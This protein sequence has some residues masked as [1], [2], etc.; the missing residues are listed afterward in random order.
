MAF[1]SGRWALTTGMEP[2]S[3]TPNTGK[4]FHQNPPTRTSFRRSWRTTEPI[5][6]KTCNV[7]V[8]CLSLAASAHSE[9]RW[10]SQ[11]L[12][13]KWLDFGKSCSCGQNSWTCCV[14][15]K[16]RNNS[17]GGVWGEL[18]C[19]V[20]K[21][22]YCW[23]G[24]REDATKHSDCCRNQ[25]L[26]ILNPFESWWKEETRPDEGTNLHKTPEVFPLGNFWSDIMMSYVY[27]N[28]NV[29]FYKKN[30]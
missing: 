2:S 18:S 30:F 25:R 5:W 28:R 8:C 7:S 27:Y 4:W 3:K 15:R 14:C 13:S 29:L 6:V 20:P 17:G 19:S 24:T 26:P 16:S 1:S 10:N 11:P 9:W 23:P 22:Y 12:W 21:W